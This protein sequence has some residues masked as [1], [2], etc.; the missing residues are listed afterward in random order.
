M[1]TPPARLHSWF[2]IPPLLL[3]VG[4][5]TLRASPAVPELK[6]VGDAEAEV[7]AVRIEGEVAIRA[8]EGLAVSLWASEKLLANAIAITMDKRGRPGSRS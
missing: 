2:A 7:D 4:A 8:A 1:M 3:V 6:Y 5:L